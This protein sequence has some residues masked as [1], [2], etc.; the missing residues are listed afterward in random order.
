MWKHESMTKIHLIRDKNMKDEAKEYYFH[1][2]QDKQGIKR[3][4]GKDNQ[5]K[6]K[7]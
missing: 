3:K 1:T 2:W 6:I 4:Q 7:Q 5:D